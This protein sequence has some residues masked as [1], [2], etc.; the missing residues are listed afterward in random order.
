MDFRIQ[1]IL[2]L[3]IGI[4]LII[5]GLYFVYLFANNIP[6]IRWDEI[7]AETHIQT[8]QNPASEE[9]SQLI[10]SALCA[11]GGIVCG[12]SHLWFLFKNKE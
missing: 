7:N 10:L 12:A 2:N 9:F 6:E 1:R 4:F 5:F 3:L 8:L 11:F